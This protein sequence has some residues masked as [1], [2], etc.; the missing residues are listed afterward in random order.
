[1]RTRNA[2]L[3][4]YWK[5]VDIVPHAA[6][7]FASMEVVNC[8]FG[9]ILRRQIYYTCTSELR[10]GAS[11]PTSLPT[12]NPS[13]PSGQPTAV[14]TPRMPSSAPS[15]AAPTFSTAVSCPFFSTTFSYCYL[16]DAVC[17]SCSFKACP[18]TTIQVQLTN[19]DR[20]S[21]QE[22]T[23]YGPTGYYVFS[24]YIVPGSDVPYT[25]NYDGDCT[26]FT[27]VATCAYGK[28]CSGAYVIGEAI[29]E[30]TS[31]PTA[32]P[33]GPSVLPTSL[34]PTMSPTVEESIECPFYH[35][36]NTSMATKVYNLIDLTRLMT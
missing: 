28:S 31:A 16:A 4:S 29:V 6:R 34:R 30:P 9:D 23:I 1:M 14:P 10:K 11:P 12:I 33:T 8:L 27:L 17:P 19:A 21:Y 18:S 5:A 7:R 36:S 32:V 15:S 3:T 26:S 20:D 13:G 2:R 22:F 24:S 25:F 35:A